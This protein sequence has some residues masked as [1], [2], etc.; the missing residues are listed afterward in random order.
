MAWTWDG[1]FRASKMDDDG[2]VTEKTFTSS[3]QARQFVEQAENVLLAVPTTKPSR[4]SQG[5]RRPAHVTAPA[6][7]TP[8]QQALKNEA[9]K[10]VKGL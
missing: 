6:S 9:M 10:Q 3:A 4:N 2:T 7:L 1:G 5:M 8:E